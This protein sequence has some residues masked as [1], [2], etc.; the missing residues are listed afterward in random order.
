MRVCC[1]NQQLQTS[2]R[3]VAESRAIYPNG[4]QSCSFVLLLINTNVGVSILITLFCTKINK[5]KQYYKQLIVNYLHV[6]WKGQKRVHQITSVILDI[7]FT[8]S[9]FSFWN[10]SHV[11][12]ELNTAVHFNYIA[13]WA[14]IC[15]C[16]GII[17]I[18][19]VPSFVFSGW[20]EGISSSIF[21][22]FISSNSS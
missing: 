2:L 11:F 4:G 20:S 8:L 15:N 10:V 1:Q 9:N 5:K 18:S 16:S 22:S 17:P 19:S 14:L 12:R 6:Q 3:A 13:R 7:R 21:A